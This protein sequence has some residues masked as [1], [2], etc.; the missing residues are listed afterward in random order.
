M[1]FEKLRERPLEADT[2]LLMSHEVMFDDIPAIMEMWSWEGITASSVIFLK[3]DVKDKDENKLK[4]FV[5]E[6]IKQP[7]DPQ[8]T[9]KES[10]DF[11]FISFNFKTSD[12]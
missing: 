4:A 2:D 3:E 9:I 5:F 6:K 11:V 8:T 1:C 7:V 12:D 10:G